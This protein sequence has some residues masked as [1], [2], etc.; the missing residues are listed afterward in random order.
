LSDVA[1]YERVK[2][3]KEYPEGTTLFQL[4]A[5]KGQV[6]YHR[7]GLAKTM[8][9]AIIPKEGI[10]P[11][12]FF[13]VFELNVP[14]FMAKMQTGLNLQIGALDSFRLDLHEDIAVQKL[15]ADQEDAVQVQIDQVKAEIEREKQLKAYMLNNMFV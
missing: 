5:T 13:Y 9:A 10:D 14:D 12:Y 11:R 3:T 1:H 7:G 6:V 15:I 8:Y 4:S 2:A